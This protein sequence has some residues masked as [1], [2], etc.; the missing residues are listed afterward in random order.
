[1]Y[2]GSQNGQPLIEGVTHRPQI[3]SP[4]RQAPSTAPILPAT[5]TF[6]APRRTA[7][8]LADGAATPSVTRRPAT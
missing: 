2:L 3:T 7:G 5:L 6:T 4:S 8:T 1:M